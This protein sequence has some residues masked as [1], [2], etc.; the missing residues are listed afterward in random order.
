MVSPP[1]SQGP[2]VRETHI[3]CAKRRG[4]ATFFGVS[5]LQEDGQGLGGTQGEVF[6]MKKKL[7]RS[8]ASPDSFFYLL[9]LPWFG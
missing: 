6:I 1:A 4:F 7:I 3:S 2:R 8:T 9:S 5:F